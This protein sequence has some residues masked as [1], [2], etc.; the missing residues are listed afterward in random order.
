MWQGL[1]IQ[2]AASPEI[3]ASHRAEGLCSSCPQFLVL[4]PIGWEVGRD[5]S[6]ANLF[7]ETCVAPAPFIH[8]AQTVLFTKATHDNMP[9][10]A[11]AGTAHADTVW[12][13]REIH[14]H[15]PVMSCFCSRAARS[16]TCVAHFVCPRSSAAA[17]HAFARMYVRNVSNVS[18]RPFPKLYSMFCSTPSRASSN[19]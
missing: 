10:L 1:W 6:T 15:S 13:L 5:G 12:V 19:S 4:L 8:P 16:P 3:A 14:C 11:K 9:V 18:K 2:V 7:L 17:A